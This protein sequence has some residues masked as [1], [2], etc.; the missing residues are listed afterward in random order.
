MKKI[1]LLSLLF[2]AEP[3]F[4]ACKW[5]WVDHDYNALTPAIQKQVCDSSIDLQ[6][7]KPAQVAPIQQPRIQPI[8][9]PVVPPIG[10][11]SCRVESVFENGRWVDKRICR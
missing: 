11:Q 6:V 3:A 2:L 5:V 7:I 9:P 8:L 1:I 10:T 4:S